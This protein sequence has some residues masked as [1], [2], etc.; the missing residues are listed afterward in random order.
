MADSSV[1]RAVKTAT[2]AF[3]I[4]I[5]ARSESDRVAVR[6]RTRARANRSASSAWLSCARAALS[7]SRAA[8]T[9][10]YCCFTSRAT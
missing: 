4:W 7:D 6:A 3:P 5:S 1:V 10:K 9:L 8:S 2:C